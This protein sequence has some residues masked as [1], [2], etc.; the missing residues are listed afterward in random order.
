MTRFAKTHPL[1]RRMLTAIPRV[2]RPCRRRWTRAD[3]E[4][5]EIET[6][7]GESAAAAGLSA[8]ARRRR[9]VAR[10]RPASRLQWRL[11]AAR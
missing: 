4:L 7:A 9:D 3:R 5:V 1:I 8:A 2:R 6:S 11:T 10:S